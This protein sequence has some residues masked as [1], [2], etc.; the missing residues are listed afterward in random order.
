MVGDDSEL[1]VSAV[2]ES[3]KTRPGVSRSDTVSKLGDRSEKLENF[4][5]MKCVEILL[6]LQNKDA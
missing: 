2:D 3:P 5:D 1:G 4:V 6:T